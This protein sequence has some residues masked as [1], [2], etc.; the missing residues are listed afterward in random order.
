MSK[1]FIEELFGEVKI[2]NL[3][4]IRKEDVLVFQFDYKKLD[5]KTLGMF[6]KMMREEGYKMLALPIFDTVVDKYDIENALKLTELA[7]LSLEQMKH[8]L[9]EA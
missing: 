7:K 9:I 2:S 6:M 5:G 4:E 1:K 3:G 8:E